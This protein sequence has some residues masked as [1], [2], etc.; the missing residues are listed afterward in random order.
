M[1]RQEFEIERKTYESAKNAFSKKYPKCWEIWGDTIEYLH[2]MGI[3]SEIERSCGYAI[4][5]YND[6]GYICVILFDECQKI[7]E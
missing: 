5:V 7:D 1:F 4:H 2:R 6:V 3:E